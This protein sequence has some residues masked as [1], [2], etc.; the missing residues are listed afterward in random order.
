MF[1]WS[2]S[3]KSRTQA[4]TLCANANKP[5][6]DVQ[7][8]INENYIP[9]LRISSSLF[10]IF[11]LPL[12]IFLFYQINKWKLCFSDVV[13]YNS[14]IY[15]S[16]LDLLICYWSYRSCSSYGLLNINLHRK[17]GNFVIVVCISIEHFWNFN[18]INLA[19]RL[20]VSVYLLENHL[21]TSWGIHF[22]TYTYKI[23]GF[24]WWKFWTL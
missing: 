15:I 1:L 19:I 12:I 8:V 4:I 3:N 5:F 6:I 23:Y 22:T 20:H 18:I 2:I 24:R 9:S 10:V 13:F 11:L 7:Y 16:I 21:Y 17:N 14:V